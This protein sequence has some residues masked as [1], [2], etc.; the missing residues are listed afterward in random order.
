M[1]GTANPLFVGANPTPTSFYPL[2]FGFYMVHTVTV[3]NQYH[4]RKYTLNE[5]F[6]SGWSAT[7]AYVLGFWYADGY[8]RHERSYRVLFF[9]NDRDHLAQI[10]S[11]MESNSPIRTVVKGVSCGGLCLHSKKLYSDLALLGGIRRKSTSMKLPD[12]PPNYFRDF[13][14]G[15]F[16]GDGS[17]HFISYIATKNHKRYTDIRSNFTS[18]DLSF[19]SHIRDLLTNLLGLYP[20]VIGQFGPHQFKLGYAQKDTYTLMRYMY[21]PGNPIALARKEKYLAYFNV[22]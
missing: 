16:D 3:M 21:Y 19:I 12:I 17:V 18:G 10:A 13:L 7:M 5:D 9:S 6:F 2:Y 11:V 14:R 1:A 15:Y 22:H 4:S 8:M 20:R